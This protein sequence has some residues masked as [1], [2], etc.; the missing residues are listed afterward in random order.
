MNLQ[1]Y[2]QNC[3]LSTFS[4]LN[5]FFLQSP[6]CSIIRK[7]FLILLKYQ[8]ITLASSFGDT[9]RAND[10]HPNLIMLCGQYPV[11]SK[12]SW[13]FIVASALCTYFAGDGTHKSRPRLCVILVD[14][15]QM[16]SVQKVMPDAWYSAARHSVSLFMYVCERKRIGQTKHVTFDNQTGII[17]LWRHR[18]SVVVWC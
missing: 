14:T 5:R 17:P 7:Y 2:T 12:L 4:K 10:C 8:F 3:A 11:A 1:K 15:I 18:C 13:Y 9:T 6:D 16:G